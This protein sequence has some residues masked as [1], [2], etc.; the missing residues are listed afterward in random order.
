MLNECWHQQCELNAVVE[1]LTNPVEAYLHTECRRLL[2]ALPRLEE[3]WR[4]QK[5]YELTL[6]FIGSDRE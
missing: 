5:G 4:D 3:P 2:V 6:E 1:Q